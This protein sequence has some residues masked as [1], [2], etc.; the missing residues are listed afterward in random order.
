MELSYRATVKVL[1]AAGILN[2]PNASPTIVNF[3]QTNV[4][5][6]NPIIVEAARRW[7]IELSRP[8]GDE[9]DWDGED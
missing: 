1:E 2:T 4:S 3:M 5:M 6:T 7:W 8:A 9:I